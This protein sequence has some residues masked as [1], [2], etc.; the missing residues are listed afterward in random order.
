MSVRLYIG[1]LSRE[2]QR[3]DFEAF[4][5][6]ENDNVVSI[7]LITDR[8]TGKCRGFGFVTVKSDFS[9]YLTSIES[10]KTRKIDIIHS[11]LRFYGYPTMRIKE[12]FV[13]EQLHLMRDYTITEW[14]FD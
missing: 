10:K 2:L 6:E 9:R 4:F 8:K 5:A 11:S 12:E 1:N 13:N 7:K 14:F 3:E